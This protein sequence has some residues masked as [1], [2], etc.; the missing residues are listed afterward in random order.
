MRKALLA[1]TAA[2]AALTLCAPASARN[3]ILR[4]NATNYTTPGW[5]ANPLGSPFQNV[6]ADDVVQPNAPSTDSGF[7]TGIGDTASY[8]GLHVAEPTLAAGENVT[9]ATAWVYA[10][11]GPL[12]S[13]TVSLWSGNR[14]LAW[15]SFDPGQG[16]RWLSV[17][18]AKP[19]TPDQAKALTVLLGSE[20]STQSAQWGRTYAT[21]VELATDA[22]DPAAPPPPFPPPPTGV[23]L[24]FSTV[25]VVS[26]RGKTFAPLVLHCPTAVVARC[27][28][29]VTI[30]LLA[31][32]PKAK[33]HK[34][35]RMARCGRGCRPIGR[36]S[37]DI[38]SGKRGKVKVR[39]ALKQETL[40]GQRRRRKAKVTATT[41]DG[42]GN[43][44]VTTRVVTLT[45]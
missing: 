7:L 42:A 18:Y 34:L 28:G 22:P 12:Q 4:P 25:R 38:A 33:P 10:S 31:D 11:T 21:Y 20:G 44:T 9:G 16:A 8:A 36:G 13:L 1:G 39:M 14:F 32:A 41:R 37:F 3:H 35:V 29:T 15:R 5:V 2:V 30:H 24:A 23:K 45:H 40:F 43:R 26:E 27:K 17:P 19:L 6:L